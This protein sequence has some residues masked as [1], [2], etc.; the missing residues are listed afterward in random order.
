MLN[1]ISDTIDNAEKAIDEE[2]LKRFL[3]AVI[4]AEIDLQGKAN[5][6]S[7]GFLNQKIEELRGIVKEPTVVINKYSVDFKSSRMFVAVLFISLGLLCSLCGNYNQYQKN[8]KLTANDLKYRFVKMKNGILHDEITRL[9]N[10][11]YYPDS[12]YV[13]ENIRKDVIGY[14]H[15]VEEQARKL[16]QKRQS[17][18]KIDKLDREIEELK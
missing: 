7:T 6:A 13:V 11:F 1:K 5:K 16:E 3:N 10:F 4:S 9:E 12:T 18:E 8:R 2:D 15:R 14:E 17:E